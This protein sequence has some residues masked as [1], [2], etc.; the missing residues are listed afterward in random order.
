M[1]YRVIQAHDRRYPIRLLCRALTVS[2]AGYYAWRVR[3]TSARA[4]ANRELLTE[5]RLLHRDRRQTY[6]SLVCGR[7]SYRVARLMRHAGLHAKTVKKWL[8]TTHSAHQCPVASN[9]LNRQFTVVVPN[10][11]WAGTSPSSGSRRAGSI[12]PCFSISTRGL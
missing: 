11:V 1:R 4:P 3:P 7:R 10:Q 9:Q 12:W 8:A 5:V 6:G 2:A